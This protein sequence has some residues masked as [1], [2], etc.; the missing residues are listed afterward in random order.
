MASILVLLADVALLI[1]FGANDTKGII[2]AAILAALRV[3]MGWWARRLS[4]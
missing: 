4:P 1:I 2:F 3:P